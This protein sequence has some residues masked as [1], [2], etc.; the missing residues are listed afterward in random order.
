MTARLQVYCT[1]RE[2][3]MKADAGLK[4]QSRICLS[5]CS[6]KQRFRGSHVQVQ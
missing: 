6:K 3:G 4:A 1:E 2:I 5:V